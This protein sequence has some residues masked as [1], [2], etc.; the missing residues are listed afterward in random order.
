MTTT[1]PAA[2]QWPEAADAV[3][4]LSRRSPSSLQPLLRLLTY[5]RRHRKYAA[6]TI[7]FGAAGFLLSFVYPWLIGSAVDVVMAPTTAGIPAVEGRAHLLL[8]TQLAAGTAVLHALVVYGRGHFNVHLSDGIITDLRR[9]LFEH[10]QKL[11]LVFY[12]KQRTGSILSRLMQDVHEATSII[13]VGVIVAAMDLIQLLIAVALLAGI[14]VKLTVACLAVFPLYG[15]VFKRF[16]PRVRAISERLHQH[17]SSISGNVAEQLAGQALVK[18]YT[19]EAR[20]ARRFSSQVAEH[21]QLVVA[22]SHQGHLVAAAGEVLVHF[23]TT[24]VLGYGGWLAIQGELTA[25]MVTRFL[26][27]VVIMYGPVRRFAELNI[28]YQSSL[29]AIRRVFSVFGIQPAVVDKP[30]ALT[31]PPVVGRVRFE[32]VRFRYADDSDEYQARLEDGSCATRTSMVDLTWVL[33]DV[34]LD[35]RAGEKI[36]VVGPSGAGKTT[37][38]SL[39]PRLY[40]VSDGR[41]LIDAIDIRDYSVQALRSAIAIVQQ[42]SFLFTGTIRDNIAYGK[43]DASSKE[44]VAAAKAANAHEFI[45]SFHDGYETRLG[46]RGVNLSGGQRQRISIARALLKN[47]RILILDKATSSLDAESESVVQ[48][49]LEKLMRGRTS[50]IIAHRLSTIRHADKIVVLENG[51]VSECGTHDELLRRGGIYSRLVHR[52]TDAL[53]ADTLERGPRALPDEAVA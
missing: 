31:E 18:T 50:F 47:P 15:L 48:G 21:H 2:E 8:L 39:L 11:S 41:I 1:M 37:L 40:D 26:G 43:P 22:Q 34:T 46:E 24:I 12:T 16:N 23:G 17:Y 36:A 33:N 27:Y 10:L 29:S 32:H 7:A 45:T 6:L 38:L 51:R 19:A 14:S 25:G 4:S 53:D 49:A 42:D 5:V 9:E 13:Y 52:Q 3:L 44:V 30:R 20:E 28:T 35:A